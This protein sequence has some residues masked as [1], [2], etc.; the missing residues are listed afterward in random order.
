MRMSLY[1]PNVVTLWVF[2]RATPNGVEALVEFMLDEDG[3]HQPSLFTRAYRLGAYNTDF[4]EQ[5]TGR[6]AT[7]LVRDAPQPYR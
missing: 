1:T 5:H 2:R 3:E 6:C 7:E 4:T